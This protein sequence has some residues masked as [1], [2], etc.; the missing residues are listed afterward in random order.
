MASKRPLERLLLIDRRISSALAMIVTATFF[1]GWRSQVLTQAC[2]RWRNFL[3]LVQI[4]LFLVGVELGS[5]HDPRGGAID[6][7][8]VKPC[9]RRSD[10]LAQCRG[11]LPGPDSV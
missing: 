8:S 5:Q 4:E 6:H 1:I 11:R 9:R 2:Q 3:A 10:C 7:D